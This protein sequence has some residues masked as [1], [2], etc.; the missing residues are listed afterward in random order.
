MLLLQI[1]FSDYS[2]A[3]ESLKAVWYFSFKNIRNISLHSTS[4]TKSF[5]LNPGFKITLE[6]TSEDSFC[7]LDLAVWT[8]AILSNDITSLILKRQSFQ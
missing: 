6:T 1:N 4:N 7:Y 3:P 5:C 2:N 8:K